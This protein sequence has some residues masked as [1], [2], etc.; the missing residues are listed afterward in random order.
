MNKIKKLLYDFN[1]LVMFKH[2]IFAL[3][4]IFIVMITSSNGWF[5]WK[6]FFLGIFATI[7]A[8]NFAMA[9]NRYIDKNIDSKNPRTINRP[10]VDGRLSS[11]FILTFITLKSRFKGLY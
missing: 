1:E 4:F 6:L 10:S 7:T 9:F 3:P 8:R 11:K 2:S 5:G